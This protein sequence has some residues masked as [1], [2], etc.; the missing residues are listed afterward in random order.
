M[1]G[2]PGE[3]VAPT[4]PCPFPLQAVPYGDSTSPTWGRRSCLIGITG[5]LLPDPPTALGTGPKPPASSMYSL[6]PLPGRGDSAPPRDR[7]AVAVAGVL[8]AAVGSSYLRRISWAPAQ[9]GL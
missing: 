6:P 2:H 9:L 3:L 7:A 1:P 8:L 5:K 4:A